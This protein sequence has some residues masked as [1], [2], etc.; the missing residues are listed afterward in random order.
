MTKLILKI[1]FLKLIFRDF[2]VFLIFEAHKITQLPLK[3]NFFEMVSR[4]IF[5]FSSYFLSFYRVY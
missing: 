5:I 2:F 1:N 3:V 4:N